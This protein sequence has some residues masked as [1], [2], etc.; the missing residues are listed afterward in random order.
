MYG[1]SPNTDALKWAI[2]AGSAAA[3][4]VYFLAASSA[5]ETAMY[6]TAVKPVSTVPV[7]ALPT[8]GRPA[9]PTATNVVVGARP[10][11]VTQLEAYQPI[12]LDAI[13]TQV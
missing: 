10:A 1:T 8:M 6:S 2:A 12:Q 11:A 3:V 9:L 7:A 5:P 4:V 13:S